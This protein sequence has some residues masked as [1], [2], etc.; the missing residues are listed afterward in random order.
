MATQLL[1]FQRAM[2]LTPMTPPAFVKS[3]AAIRSP[4]GRAVNAFTVLFVPDPNVDQ[5]SDTGS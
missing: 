3:P 5:V 2:R 4:F 1:P